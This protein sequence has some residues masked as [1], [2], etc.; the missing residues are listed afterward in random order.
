MDNK[1]PPSELN[2]TTRGNEQKAFSSGKNEYVS[3]SGEILSKTIMQKK[4][5]RGVKGIKAT[6]AN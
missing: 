5:T 6:K 4:V 1:T 3:T 2:Y